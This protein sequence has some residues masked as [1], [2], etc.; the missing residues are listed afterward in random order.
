MIHQY[1]VW[2]CSRTTPL[3]AT[4]GD[5]ETTVFS[6]TRLVCSKKTSLNAV[7]TTLSCTTSTELH[8]MSLLALS[9]LEIFSTGNWV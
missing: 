8:S 7:C 2:R 1:S 3:N 9:T 5:L 6:A 4:N